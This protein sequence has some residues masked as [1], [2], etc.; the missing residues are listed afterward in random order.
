MTQNLRE[1]LNL[2]DIQL[3]DH[4]ILNKDELER[5]P[6]PPPPGELNPKKEKRISVA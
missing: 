2:I 5:A 1:A 3:L 6:A 4:L